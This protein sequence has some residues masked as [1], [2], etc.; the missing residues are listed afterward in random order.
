[1]RLT[2][3]TSEGCYIKAT[4]VHNKQPSNKDPNK[5]ITFVNLKEYSAASGFEDKPDNPGGIDLNAILG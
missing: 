1:M 3:R 4:V 2:I 5:T